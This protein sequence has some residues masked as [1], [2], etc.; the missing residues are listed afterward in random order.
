M[1]RFKNI[2]YVAESAAGLKAF[3]HAAGLA[4]RNKARLTVVLVMEELPPYLTR[5]TPHMVRQGPTH[6]PTAALHKLR[7]PAAGRVTIERQT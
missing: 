3:H 5:L 6:D 4:E 7:N 1:K 2:L